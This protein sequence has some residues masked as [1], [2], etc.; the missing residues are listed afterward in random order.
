MKLF[1]LYRICYMKLKQIYL[2]LRQVNQYMAKIQRNEF[3]EERV[4]T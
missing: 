3:L 1:I 2:V 4:K